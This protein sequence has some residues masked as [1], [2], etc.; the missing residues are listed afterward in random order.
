M[1]CT[2]FVDLTA[3]P[4]M[5]TPTQTNS[6]TE[7]L[8]TMSM[9]PQTPIAPVPS[10]S[11]TSTVP[12]V[13]QVTGGRKRKASLDDKD[14]KTRERIL[15][16]RA[17]AQDSRDKKRRYVADL[18]DANNDLKTDN[19]RLSKRVKVVEE[20]NAILS[21]R[22][23]SIAAQLSQIQS[24]LRFNEITQF[25]FDG[26]RESAALASV[27]GRDRNARSHV[28]GNDKHE[29]P[30]LRSQPSISQQR[31]PSDRNKVMTST[32]ASLANRHRPPRFTHPKTT[33]LRILLPPPKRRLRRPR[34]PTCRLP[35]SSRPRLTQNS[36][37]SQA[38][39]SMLIF[40]SM[41]FL[42]GK[43][44]NLFYPSSFLRMSPYDYMSSGRSEEEI[45]TADR[46]LALFARTL[47][48]GNP[49]M[50]RRSI[51]KWRDEFAKRPP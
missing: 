13:T 39:R 33:T 25:L 50:N 51:L 42:T 36:S 44:S 21:A 48:R 49:R 35:P 28:R 7:T 22:L 40:F 26:F 29:E 37:S 8:T 43:A 10:T 46:A 9:D 19:E 6:T 27:V 15:R 32:T 11:T 34:A 20:E 31:K 2:N 14:A 47:E 38:F 4:D 24:Q 3:I 17:A 30:A 16:N 12:S 23:E 41:I 5:V 45:A 18:E 1:S